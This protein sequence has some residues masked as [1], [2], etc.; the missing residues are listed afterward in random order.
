MKSPFREIVLVVALLFVLY[1][2]IGLVFYSDTGVTEE[3]REFW[4]NAGNIST[5]NKTQDNTF[6]ISRDVNISLEDGCNVTDINSTHNQT[7]IRVRCE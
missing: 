2:A 7:L 1:L 3:E 5:A 4:E 6:Y